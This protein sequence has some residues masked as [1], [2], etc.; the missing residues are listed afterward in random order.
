[1][2]QISVLIAFFIC[3]ICTP[4]QASVLT[5]YNT[6]DRALLHRDQ[7]VVFDEVGSLATSVGYLHVAI[8]LNIT[9]LHDQAMLLAFSLQNYTSNFNLSETL[10]KSLNDIIH[11]QIS[12]LDQVL[13]DLITL[14]SL[15]PQNEEPYAFNDRLKRNKRFIF[16]PWAI[17]AQVDSDT[18][19]YEKENFKRKYNSLYL[20]YEDLYKKY[21]I[22]LSENEEYRQKYANLTAFV[23]LV[24]EKYPLDIEYPEVSS[25]QPITKNINK[26]LKA[27]HPKYFKDL[28]TN[29][30]FSTKLTNPLHLTRQ[31]RALG[32]IA[33]GAIGTFSGLLGTFMGLYNSVELSKISSQISNVQ[34]QST[35]LME[36]TNKHDRAIHELINDIESL[37]SAINGL[38]VH[39]PAIL[40][41]KLDNHVSVFQKRV[42]QSINCI[43]QLQNRRL[44]I[45]FLDKDVLQL[46][47]EAL[48]SQAE[49]LGYELLTHKTSDY[50][51]LETSYLRVDNDIVIVVHV[52]CMSPTGKL[53]MYKYIP[54]PFPIKSPEIET[55]NISISNFLYAENV[56]P[57]HF[58]KQVPEALYIKSDHEFIAIGEEN[59]FVELS[60]AELTECDKHGKLYICQGHQI[61]QTDLLD[62]CLGSLF[63]RE[64]TKLF[65]NCKIERKPLKEQ[66]FQLTPT[67]FLLFSPEIFTTKLKCRNN[68]YSNKA[69]FVQGTTQIHVPPGC[70]VKLKNHLVTS[71]LNVRVSPEPVRAIWKWNPL[72]FP[73]SMLE[74]VKMVESHL[75]RVA[76]SVKTLRNESVTTDLFEKLHW[77]KLHESGIFPWVSV[78]SYIVVLILLVMAMWLGYGL[79]KKRRASRT[80]DA[81]EPTAQT[82]ISVSYDSAR[83]QVHAPLLPQY[84]LGAHYPNVETPYVEAKP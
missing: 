66:V 53:K 1:M 8:P 25:F 65:D 49:G 20:E 64:Q 46:M 26:L 27:K 13:S 78:V 21:N 44:A 75:N 83:E 40:Q 23:K 28:S 61:V 31:R 14:D 58:T 15:L 24:R 3:L 32:V 81:V 19:W 33:L 59:Q 6:L 5:T 55:S 48:K 16:L 42:L 79:W 34:K 77:L 74:D 84:T 37:S 54:Y 2:W 12:K 62:S 11:F 29:E 43:Q 36:I 18:Y 50:F 80:N 63:M 10:G 67:D 17:K 9:T 68:T 30:S 45:D 4:S 72:E 70:Q 7:Y 73:A 51:Q 56:A 60:E 41:A 22:V 39:N 82:H 76:D 35:L 57:T 52:P 47:H 71:D 69:I 38:I